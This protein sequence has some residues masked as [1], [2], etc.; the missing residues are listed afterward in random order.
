MKYEE[1]PFEDPK[2]AEEWIQAIETEKEG[3]RDNEIYPLLNKWSGELKPKVLVEVGSGQGVCSAK[4]NIGEGKYIGVEPSITLT[5]RAKNL[6]PETNKQF[7]LGSAYE[8]PLENE[9]ADAAFSVG[10]W[11]HLEDLDKAHKE[12]NRILKPGAELLI[13]TSNPNLHDVWESWFEVDSKEG[14]KLIGKA[15]T[16]S[17]YLSRSVFFLHPEED[18]TSSLEKNG[19]KIIDIKKFGFGKDR[20]R[21]DEGIWMAI[22]AI[23]G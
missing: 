10:V 5:E 12:M 22:K 9:V 23:K 14:K 7:L 2:S 15:T 18:I 8:M 4:V 1:N 3:S 11:F 16:P 13:I 6:Y 21:D 17:G 20:Y 19:F